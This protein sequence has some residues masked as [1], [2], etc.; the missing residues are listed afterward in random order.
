MDRLILALL[1]AVVVVGVAWLVQRRRPDP[2]TGSGRGYEPPAQ[3][4]RADFVR[5]EAPWLV[6]VFSSAT[7]STCGDVWAKTQVLESGE[8]AIQ[9]VEAVADADLHH[10]Y[11]IEAVPIVVIAGADGVVVSSFMGP[12]SATHL[13]AALAEAR[14][15]GS[16]PPGCGEEHSG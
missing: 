14:E 3:L 10:R 8:V 2:P 13:W 5:P 6:V 12:V 9:Q 16:V 7:C 1:L 15:P 11:R 4:D